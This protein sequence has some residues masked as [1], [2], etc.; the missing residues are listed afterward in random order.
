MAKSNIITAID[1]GT[2][3]MKGL[4]VQWRNGVPEPEVIA[5]ATEPTEGMR[6]GVVSNVN[7]VAQGIKNLVEKLWQISQRRPT[8]IITNIGGSHIF[9][10]SSSG[11]VAVSRADQRI[12]SEDIERA[13]SAAQAFSLPPNK[14]VLDFWPQEYIVDQERGV[15]EP[16]GMKGI[17][18][19]VNILALCA[20]SPYVKNVSEAVTGAG[21]SL[22]DIIPSALA[23]AR[24]VLTPRQKELGCA[25]L[26][27][28]AR[29]TDL[30]VF[31]DGELIH[32]AVFPVGSANI[33][34][35]IAIALRID[36]DLAERVKLEFG[37]NFVGRV[38]KSGLK[39]KGQKKVTKPKK[40]SKRNKIE[41]ETEDGTVFSFS[42]SELGKVVDARLRDI[43]DE[44]NKELKRI[45][46][47]G[48]L[49]AGVVLTGGGAKL[50]NLCEVSKRELKLPCRLG[51]PLGIRGIEEDPAWSVVCGLALE[52]LSFKEDFQHRLF[53]S[54]VIEKIKKFLSMFI[55]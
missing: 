13:L 5:M 53:G 23:S 21:F 49:P 32:V 54:G 26:D 16:L 43:F 46:R 22:M 19:D 27:I 14:E 4:Q 41:I 40:T 3:V 28:G 2:S 35:D 20:F 7:L 38:V 37:A 45:S 52:G 25:V 11:G 36:T 6:K 30:A 9:V 48:L 47:Q 33:T 31:E 8:E 12:S 44:V 1:I 18:L 39:R 29:T 42:A 51:V 55:P 17:R 50:A 10:T 24:A 34:D 15:K